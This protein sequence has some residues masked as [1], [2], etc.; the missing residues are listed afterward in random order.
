[1]ADFIELDRDC[2]AYEAA[3][4]PAESPI[5]FVHGFMSHRGVWARTI[6]ALKDQHYCIAVDLLGFGDSSKPN[7]GD[8]SIRAQ[9]ERVLRI[10]DRLGL[11]QF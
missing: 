8:Y 4:K 3:G 11:R 10:G 9:A 6:D 7:R 2:F 1:M 5:V